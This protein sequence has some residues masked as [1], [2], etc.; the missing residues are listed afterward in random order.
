MVK[1]MGPQVI[2][3]T[4]ETLRSPDWVSMQIHFKLTDNH[5]FKLIGTP[6][7]QLVTWCD[8]TACLLHQ[9]QQARGV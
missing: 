3:I 7:Q 5:V 9:Q 8:S 2:Q 6:K 4:A 1:A